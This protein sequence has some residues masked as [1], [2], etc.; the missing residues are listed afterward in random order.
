MQEF[1][2]KHIFPLIEEGI[3]NGGKYRFYP[4]GTSMLPL[5]REGID[6]VV[7]TETGVIKKYDIVLYQRENEAYVLHRVVKVNEDSFDMCGDNQCAIERGIKREQIKAAV[8]GFYRKDEYVSAK[9]PKHIKYAKERIASIPFR[10]FKTKLKAFFH[11]I[12]EYII[13]RKG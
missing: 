6:S 9:D 13:L 10:R 4:K 8:S 1:S 3:K 12:K 11:K 5:L 2:M 7:L